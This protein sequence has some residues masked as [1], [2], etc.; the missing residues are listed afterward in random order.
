MREHVNDMFDILKK[1]GPDA[2]ALSNAARA[3]T[4]ADTARFE[5]GGELGWCS[6]SVATADHH[7]PNSL[8]L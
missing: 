8:R 3:R 7:V 1:G 4:A 2:V 5:A 6:I